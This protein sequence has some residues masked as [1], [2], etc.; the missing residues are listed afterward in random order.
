MGN[1]WLAHD[2][3]LDRPVAVK[4]L[5]GAEPDAAAT[6][7]VLVEARAL[8]AEA[9]GRGVEVDELL[10]RLALDDADGSRA[11]RFHAPGKLVVTTTPPAR[12][13]LV[14]WLRGRDGLRRAAGAS[15]VGATPLT[16]DL[17]PGSYVLVVEAAGRETVRWPFL[18]S[19]GETLSP[20]L[21]LPASLPEGFVLVPP[22]RFL[23]GTANHEM[24]NF[25][26]TASRPTTPTSTRPTASSRWR[27][28]PMRSAP[29]RRRAAPSASTT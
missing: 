20:S 11:R 7:R 3:L 28:G 1:V 21:M 15:A 10:A 4:F 22:G 9:H 24:R 6:E 8:N 23:F 19:R 26:G 27:S 12:A 29:T 14:A 18:L 17:M 16:L 5:A 25:E 2:L 13:S